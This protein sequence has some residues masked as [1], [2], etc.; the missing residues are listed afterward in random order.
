MEQL[1]EDSVLA[2]RDETLWMGR[3]AI[4][5]VGR[6]FLQKTSEHWEDVVD[7]LKGFD[8]D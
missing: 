7:Y 6:E 8:D 3:V 2:Y 5:A 1:I 4:E